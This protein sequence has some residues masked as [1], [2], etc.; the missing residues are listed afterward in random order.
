[1][2]VGYQ[3]KQNLESRSWELVPGKCFGKVV[4]K[5]GVMTP[6]DKVSI[7]WW[8]TPK[9]SSGDCH[10]YRLVCLLS[11]KSPVPE[12]TCFMFNPTSGT[13]SS[14]APIASTV[15]PY[16]S[17]WKVRFETCKIHFKSFNTSTPFHFK[18]LN[19]Q[20]CTPFLLWN[21]WF[22]RQNS[23]TWFTVTFFESR[24][25]NWKLIVGIPR[26]RGWINPGNPWE[27]PPL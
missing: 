16:W 7:F 21:Q 5:S 22:T 15:D 18:S 27:S 23:L 2:S 17:S 9:K 26:P 6:T 14:C 25:F 4:R 1:M 13:P 10:V 11:V 3:V 19:T 8:N 24:V 20:A 12:T